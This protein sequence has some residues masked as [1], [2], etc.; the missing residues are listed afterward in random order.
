MI[1]SLGLEGDVGFHARRRK[2][3]KIL[4][5]NLHWRFSLQVVGGLRIHPQ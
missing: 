2:D 3:G 4:L 5:N 1:K